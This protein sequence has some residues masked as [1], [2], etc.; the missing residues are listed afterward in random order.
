MTQTIIVVGGQWGDEGKGKI[1]DFLAE[2]ADVVIRYAGGNNAGHTVVVGEKKFKFH[3]IPSG[4]VHEGK[5]N[6]IGN[7]TVVDPEVLVREIESL[8]RMG[9]KIDERRLV[10]SSSAHTILPKH[11][12]EDNPKK[13][14][15]AKKI[16]TTGRGIG[17]CYRDKVARTGMRISE[18]V[19]SN[20]E[21]A[22][23]VRP[24]VK[25]TCFIINEAIDQGKKVLFEGAQGTLL[26]VDH[27]TY[28][29]VTSSNPTAGGALT[30]TG[31]GPTKIDSVIG[32][33]KAY[34]TRVGAGP[35]P[36]ELGTE[37]QTNA[38]G[39][40]KDIEPVYDKALK[41][42]LERAN[43][44]D[45]YHQG[46]YMRLMGKEY[47]TTT[48][49][50]RRTGWFDGVAARYAVMINGMS[51]MAIMKLDVLAGLRKIKICTAYEV[52]GKI[53]KN[54]ILN[55][56]KLWRV[57]PIYEELPGW[58][59]D[60]GNARSFD[61]LPVNAQN[62]LRRLEDICG[63]RIAI[64]SVGPRRDQTIVLDRTALFD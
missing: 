25:D 1:V 24:L 15:H 61:D 53:T 12:E 9:F 11:R 19:E 26:D 57:K 40:W 42:A 33:F 14:A 54:F 58:D 52:D 64:V 32:V 55:T 7:G 23:K 39:R 4:I 41:E 28:P 43:E 38:E 48:G 47:G 50:P 27:G 59:E 62:Y 46:K 30:G 21:I 31:V 34:T 51:A 37:E 5:L 3:L 56:A 2:K 45:E 8:E 17:P 63:A 49:R 35:F 13:D 10:V 18:F 29:F 6:I 36:T 20:S 22:K 16:G 60:I 44:G